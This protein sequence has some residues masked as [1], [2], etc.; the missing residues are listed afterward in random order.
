M[1]SSTLPPRSLMCL[2]AVL[3]SLIP[4]LSSYALYLAVAVV[5]EQGSPAVQ[6][7]LTGVLLLILLLVGV[8]LLLRWRARFS[9]DTA[10]RN[11]QE[12]SDRP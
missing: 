12:V 8:Q 5:L 10:T 3:F 2:A 9:K 7:T 11:D 6:G 4:V 1:H